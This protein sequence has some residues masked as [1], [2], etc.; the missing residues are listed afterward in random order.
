MSFENASSLAHENVLRIPPRQGVPPS[1]GGTFDIFT[2][3]KISGHLL[4]KPSPCARNA[5]LLPMA[6]IAA[7]AVGAAAVEVDK[8]VARFG[9]FAGADDA[10]VFQFIHDA[11]GA[12]VAQAQAALHEG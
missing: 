3:L 5:S 7:T 4:Q 6:R 8:N 2:C 12:G 11:G 10:A 1:G 9:A